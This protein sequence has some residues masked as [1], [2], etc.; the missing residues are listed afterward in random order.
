MGPARV[1]PALSARLAATDERIRRRAAIAMGL[2]GSD[3]G[4]PYL[5]KS[6]RQGSIF[7]R[8]MAAA[9]LG[10]L[11]H[12]EYAPELIAALRDSSSSVRQAAA[13]ALTRM[14]V[15]EAVPALLDAARGAK[16]PQALPPALRGA[17][18]DINELMTLLSAVRVLKGEED[19]LVLESL[20]ET[21]EN[22]WPE[23]DREV[24]KYQLELIKTYKVEEVLSADGRPVGAVLIEPS[25][26]EKLVR[27]NE[28]V[29]AGFTLADMGAGAKGAGADWVNLRR[30]DTRVTLTKGRPA[31]VFFGE[32]TRR[33]LKLRPED[34]KPKE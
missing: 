7:E 31:D 21:Q 12:R 15:K 27:P 26:K 28:N 5:V 24:F 16:S 33:D 29:A 4:A 1:L 20:P 32:Y 25:G 19:T 18:P 9:L 11:Q 23:Y 17:M 6:L 8:Q 10:A 13:I 3:E 14:D 2:L 30:G 22:R 34:L